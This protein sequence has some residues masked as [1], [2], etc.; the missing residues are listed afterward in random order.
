MN[1]SVSVHVFVCLCV[2]N[3]FCH[4]TTLFSFWLLF[5]ILLQYAIIVFIVAV[6]ELVIGIYFF[7]HLK[8]IVSAL[9][10]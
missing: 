10:S 4:I 9:S 7:T 3:T 1:A 2:H 5:Q 8:A 6:I